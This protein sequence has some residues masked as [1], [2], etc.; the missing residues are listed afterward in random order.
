MT[1]ISL[2]SLVHFLKMLLGR[3]MTSQVNTITVTENSSD[4]VEI[5]HKKFENHPNVEAINQNSSVSQD[6]YFTNTDV[7]NALKE[8]R[9]L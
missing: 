3:S 6:F 1:F 9:Q 7:I 2:K 8:H 5:A 4:F